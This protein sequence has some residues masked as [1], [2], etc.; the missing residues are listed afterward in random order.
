MVRIFAVVY[1]EGSATPRSEPKERHSMFARRARPLAVALAFA[2]LPLV[3]A[4]DGVSVR[5]D[6]SDPAASPFPSDRF[7]VRDWHNNTLSPRQ[8][9]QA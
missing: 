7:T 1:K 6:L 5:F 9:A 4:A 2:L 8:P 3:A